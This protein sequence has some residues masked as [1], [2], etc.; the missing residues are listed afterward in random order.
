MNEE[1]LKQWLRVRVAVGYLGEE[2]QFNWWPTKFYTT[3]SSTFLDPVFSRSRDVARYHGVREAAR[4]SHDNSVGIG[5]AF[6]LFRLPEEIEHSLHELMG[7]DA[8]QDLAIHLTDRDSVLDSI[9]RPGPSA[10]HITEGPALIGSIERVFS[11]SGLH[12]LAEHYFGA[13]S[14]GVRAYPYFSAE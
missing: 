10:S 14:N 2:S 1:L 4:R 7:S 9:H 8:S 11:K 13:F 12:T 3:W 5:R 6:H